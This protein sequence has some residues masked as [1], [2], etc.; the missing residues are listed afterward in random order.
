M[1]RLETGVAHDIT[2]IAD[3]CPLQRDFQDGVQRLPYLT[4]YLIH[5]VALLN[6]ALR[7]SFHLYVILTQGRNDE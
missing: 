1:G 7:L 4:L 5:L 3:D 6:V 2:H